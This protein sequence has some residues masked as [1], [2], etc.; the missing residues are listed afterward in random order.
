M[1]KPN[2]VAALTALGRVRLSEHFFMRDVNL[3]LV[4]ADYS[5]NS[6]IF[7]VRGAGGLTAGVTKG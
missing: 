7:S 5:W 6:G 4:V 3:M 1:D 2:S